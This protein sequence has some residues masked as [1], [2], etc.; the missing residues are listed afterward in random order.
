MKKTALARVISWEMQRKVAGVWVASLLAAPVAMAE[1]EVAEEADTVVVYGTELS[2]YEFDEAESATGFN[3]DVDE[4]PRSIQVLPEQLILDQNTNDLNDVLVNAAGVTRAHGFGGTELDVKIRGFSN[5]HIFVDGNPVSNRHNTDV[6]NVESA[7]VI[8]GPAS[9]LHGQV[10]PGGLINIITKKPQKESAHSI[11]AEFDEHGKRKLVLD[12]TGSLSDTLQYRVVVSGEDSETFRQVSTAEGTVDSKRE[13]LTI[14][15]SVSYTPDEQNTFTLRFSHMAQELP[16]DR[17]TVALDDGNGNLTIADI[18]RERRLG[19]E[20]DLRDSEENRI[21]FDW[22]HELDNSWVNRLKVGYNEKKFDDYQTRPLFGT[23]TTPADFDNELAL[24]MAGLMPSSVQPNGLL[25]RWTDSNLDVTESDLFLSNSITGD[26]TIGGIDNILYLGGNYTRR[27]VEHHDGFG[28]VDTP[29]ALQGMGLSPF[30]P[31]L[32]VI[33][34]NSGTQAAN[35][36]IEQTVV[37]SSD[38]THEEFGLS[39][40]NLA[41]VTDRLNVLAGLRYDRY[42]LD[43]T[44]TTLYKFAAQN[45]FDQLDDPEAVRIDSSNDNIS[46]QAGALFRITDDVSVYA[47]YSESFTPNYPDITA[48]VLSFSGDFDPEE[49]KQF[50]VGMKSSLMDDKL[51][52]TLSA[53]ELSRENVMTFENLQARLN[54][55]ERTKGLDISATM[56]FIPGLNVLAS[57]SHMDAEIVDDNSDSLNLEGNTPYNVPDNKARIWGSYEFQSGDLAG[58]GFGMGA[59]YVGDRFGNNN[60]TFELP[61]YTI[62]DA[63]AWYYVPVGAGKKLRLQGG[64][65]N[66]TDKTYYPA[67]GS[68]NAYRINVGDPRTLYLTARLEF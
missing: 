1:E 23:A 37:G 60:N 66:L 15:P 10:S 9:V 13:S 21:Q 63:A 7:E 57:Y 38:E 19:S 29:A 44:N 27:K 51:R 45:T 26:Y 5:G 41:Y 56:Q 36:R 49:A 20:F 25:G 43:K 58:L 4:L 46:G 52:V 31:D 30:M 61:G 18:P 24:A 68:G 39:I 16:I 40:Q 12:S 47:S 28:L 54:G 67:N 59:E 17:G 33:D 3:A 53:Y 8:L 64:I 22:D 14:A 6:A 34:I 2:R 62:Y 32:T 11:Q 55:E 42:E 48:G 50:E 35:R 65:K